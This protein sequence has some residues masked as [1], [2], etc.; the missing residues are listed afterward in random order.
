[1]EPRDASED[2]KKLLKK[3][4]IVALWCIR[5]K[6]IDRPSMSKMLEMLEGDVEL[7]EMPPKPTPYHEEI[8]TEGHE[9]NSKGAPISSRNSMDI[10][11]LD[12]R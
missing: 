5:M 11:I 8:S 6:P 2:E 7:L 12:G 4:V 3:I 1:M 10:T 9:G